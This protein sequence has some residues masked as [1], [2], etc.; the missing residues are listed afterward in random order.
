MDT[1]SFILGIALVVVIAVAIVAVYAFVKVGQIKEELNSIHQVIG[2]EIDNQ[3]RLREHDRRDF[4]TTIDNVYSSLD[5]K[6]NIIH[7]IIDSRFDKL[8]NKFQE[9][10]KK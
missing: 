5:E 8:E 1:L 4:E 3:N 2:S 7:R 6:A 10:V 9:Q